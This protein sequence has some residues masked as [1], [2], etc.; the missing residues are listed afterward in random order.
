MAVSVG[1]ANDQVL[2]DLNYEEDSSIETD[3]NMVITGSKH[4][5][6][7]QG[8]AEGTP[9]SYKNLTAMTDAVLGVVEQI[10]QVQESIIGHFFE[11][12]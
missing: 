2:L 1:I 8:T 3:M 12:P 5:V 6:E 7:I 4:F 9:F 11:R 10:F